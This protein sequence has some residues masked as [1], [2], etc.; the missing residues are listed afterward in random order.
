MANGLST[1]VNAVQ[2]VAAR[3]SLLALGLKLDS[4]D[5]T[6]STLRRNNQDVISFALE[7]D[8]DAHI[9]DTSNPHSVT[10]EQA[11]TAG[12][13][14][15]TQ[16]VFN[17]GASLGTSGVLKS[18]V[19]GTGLRYDL[20]MTV[21]QASGKALKLSNSADGKELIVI[22]NDGR[23]A[24]GYQNTNS[25]LPV[26]GHILS[27]VA[28][29]TEDLTG[30]PRYVGILSAIQH[31]DTAE[32]PT[33]AIGVVG[34]HHTGTATGASYGFSA[35]LRGVATT[36]T[37]ITGL[38][39]KVSAGVTAGFGRSA[40]QSFMEPTAFDQ[41]FGFAAQP[42][43]DWGHLTGFWCDFLQISS[44]GS[45][46]SA[47]PAIVSSGRFPIQ[48]Y[49]GSTSSGSPA[50]EG[51]AMYGVD[52]ATG[53]SLFPAITG[54][55]RIAY[56]RKTGGTGVRAMQA[57]WEPWPNTTTIRGG[58]ARGDT[59][60]DDGTNFTSGFWLYTTAW[61]R[62]LTDIAAHPETNG[63]TD[64]GIN[65]KGWGA[66]WLKD[67]GASFEWKLQATNTGI[68]ADRTLT[69]DQGDANRTIT[70]SGN[71]TLNDWFDQDVKTTG[72]PQHARIGIGQAA[73]GTVLLAVNDATGAPGTTATPA[74]AA[75]YGGLASSGVV[76]LGDPDNWLRVR[77]NA[78][79][80]KIPVY[81]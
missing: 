34:V 13:T 53:T 80:Y 79:T 28:A 57:Y 31:T 23:L 27:F 75:F 33:R 32:S 30:T 54:C 49:S 14:A 59:Y 48:Y 58:A 35:G 56:P 41:S 8:L 45:L 67:T 55:I 47:R 9:A 11:I 51:W 46:P 17:G 1:I 44:T 73:H 81:V 16:P 66:L 69:I 25:L 74:F 40:T 15:T 38:S 71:P 10:L 19:T 77:I 68:S 18:A 50:G 70:L 52:P 39:A 63:A 12:A 64:L 6:L 24:F 4:V 21:A 29:D 22:T 43:G 3:K 37:S 65:G 72:T 76:A 20:Q 61:G 7:S 5:K 78:T 60:F 26:D 62:A 2:D 42:G 36:S